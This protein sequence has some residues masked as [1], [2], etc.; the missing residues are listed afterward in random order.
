LT[1][2]AASLCLYQNDK[3][4]LLKE[5]IMNTQQ[6][7]TQATPAA[8]AQ[9]NAIAHYTPEQLALANIN[10]QKELPILQTASKHFVPLNIDYWSPKEAGEE[11][12]VYIH[13]IDIH[14]VPDM[15]TGEL[16]QLECVMLLE[17][18]DDTLKRLISAS[19]ILVGN[20]KDAIQRGEIIP[21]TTLTPVSITFLGKATNSS[22]SRMSNRWQIIPLIMPES[23][24]AATTAATATATESAPSSTAAPKSTKT[25]KTETQQ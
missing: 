24:K 20:I 12:L 19:R 8:T 18:Q 13:G 3:A 15:D 11:K 14:E 7:N 10:T 22:N 25:N 16:K 4:H 2:F 9:E 5:I 1:H 17:R 23:D 6:E 21:K